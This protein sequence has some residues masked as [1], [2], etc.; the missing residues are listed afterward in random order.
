VNTPFVILLNSTL[1]VI[2]VMVYER[3]NIEHVTRMSNNNI[4][5]KDNKRNKHL[6]F[7]LIQLSQL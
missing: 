2:I 1:H 7:F 4:N 6:C 5:A 3:E